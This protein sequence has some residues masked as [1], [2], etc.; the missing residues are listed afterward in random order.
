MPHLRRSRRWRGRRHIACA[1]VVADSP[2]SSASS[3]LFPRFEAFILE[4]QDAILAA[5][6]EM[7]VQLACDKGLPKRTFFR[8]PWERP[9]ATSGPTSHGVTAVLQ[10]GAVWEK[11]AAS[12]SILH[13]RLSS[14]RAASLSVPGGATYAE[15]DRYSACA[16]SLVFHS[17]S[18][19]VPTFR[20]DVRLFEL[21]D[22]GERWFGGGADLTPFYLDEQDARSFHRFWRQVCCKVVGKAAEG[23]VL[24][25]RW[26]RNCDS[27]FWIPARAEHRGIGGIFF[28]QLRDVGGSL[29]VAEQLVREVASGFMPSYLP[30][31]KRHVLEDYSTAQRRWQ[32]LRRGRYIEFNLLYDRGVR[33]GLTRLEKVMVSAPPLV[34]WEYGQADDTEAAEADDGLLDVLRQPRDWA[35]EPEDGELVDFLEEASSQIAGTVPR[36]TAMQCRL[37]VRGIGVLICRS[38]GDG[39][40]A[41]NLQVLC[42]RRASNKR[43]FPD[44]WDMFVGGLARPGEKIEEAAARELA[45][46]LGI[47]NMEKRLSAL[48]PV[49]DV[50]N[51]VVCC[52]C[53][54]FALC[55][56]EDQQVSNPDG[57]VAET[58]WDRIED[59][60]AKVAADRGAWVDSGLQVWDAIEA[61]GDLDSVLNALVR[62]PIGA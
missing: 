56:S 49:V 51:E 22:R 32:L 40:D 19:C 59:L 36:G 33:F 20:S 48:G 1:G 62:A 43:D 45:E 17:R 39:G 15:G 54:V 4:Q 42:Q 9:S 23:D 30:I 24:Y 61:R 3:D 12:T 31:A 16:L 58:R 38:V 5:A 8:E 11:A 2:T 6:E 27:Y 26:K 18:P 52:G 21:P 53:Q 47:E 14:E 13:G 37:R 28:D 50:V 35:F 46:E 60:R 57:E 10:E 55:V 7:E 34:A 29:D 44:R 25:A 41:Q